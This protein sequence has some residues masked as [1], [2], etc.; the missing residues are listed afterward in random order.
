MNVKLSKKN[1]VIT[2]RVDRLVEHVDTTY[3]DKGQVFDAVK[4]AVL[5]KGGRL[6][7][8]QLTEELIRLG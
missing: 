6:S 1:G 8:V 2:V 4:Y 5:S 3:K 7:D